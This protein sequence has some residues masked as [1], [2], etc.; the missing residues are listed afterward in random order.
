VIEAIADMIGMRRTLSHTRLS[1]PV[2][3]MYNPQTSINLSPAGGEGIGDRRD[4]K[5]LSLKKV[6]SI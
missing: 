1:A 5:V 4:E 2:T 3:S 6:Y